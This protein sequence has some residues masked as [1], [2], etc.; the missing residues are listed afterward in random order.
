MVILRKL[1]GRKRW[2]THQNEVKK[3]Y[4]ALVRW[5]YHLEGWAP[6][7]MT[8]T[9]TV[10]RNWLSNGLLP[11]TFSNFEIVIGMRVIGIQNQRIKLHQ[12]K[13]WG[14]RLWNKKLKRVTLL[15]SLRQSP[16]PPPSTSGQH[17][18]TGGRS[19]TSPEN[20]HC[21]VPDS[22]RSVEDE[23]DVLLCL[24]YPCMIHSE[25]TCHDLDS[26]MRIKSSI[27]S[28]L[29]SSRYSCT[30]SSGATRTTIY[31][32]R[33]Q[34]RPAHGWPSCTVP[35]CTR[36]TVVHSAALYPADRRAAVRRTSCRSRPATCCTCGSPRRTRCGGPPAAETAP[37]WCPTTT[38]RMYVRMQKN[39]SL[40]LSTCVGARSAWLRTVSNETLIVLKCSHAEE[41]THDNPMR[42]NGSDACVGAFLWHLCI[43]MNAVWC[44][45]GTECDSAGVRQQLSTKLHWDKK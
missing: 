45:L 35:P 15:H 10:G 37:G 22:F 12:K 5:L 4:F 6:H 25:T 20:P 43:H 27:M 42:E 23:Q 38:V 3:Q 1:F 9:V 7:S 26:K 14:A 30:Y 13:M 28:C 39:S 16:P 24:F 19:A 40:F 31:V 29:A 11:Q 32:L 21:L 33:A 41:L 36:L 44:E 2:L 17:T 8:K 34:W 18:L